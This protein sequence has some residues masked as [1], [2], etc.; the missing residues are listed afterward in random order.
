MIQHTRLATRPRIGCTIGA[1]HMSNEQVPSTRRQFL[2]RETAMA[3]AA[4]AFSTGR[5]LGANDRINIAFIGNG[6]QF[7]GLIRGCDKKL[8]NEK[9]VKGEEYLNLLVELPSIKRAA[10]GTSIPNLRNFSDE[11]GEGILLF[12]PVG[13][14]ALAMAVGDL[15][16]AGE[17][18]Q[19]IFASGP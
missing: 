5:V 15:M 1:S 8:A 12:R 17:T 13:Q 18:L 10:Q 2:A 3:A 14:T 4:T 19:K 16:G 9:F 7:E 11:N 6:M